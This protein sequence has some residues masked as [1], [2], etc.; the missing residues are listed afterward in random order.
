MQPPSRLDQLFRLARRRRLGGGA[1]G[2]A[3]SGSRP[4]KARAVWPGSCASS[5]ASTIWPWITDAGNP[6]SFDY[7]VR[8]IGGSGKH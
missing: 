6:A 3:N 7:A 8:A 4:A 1:E 2:T 5:F